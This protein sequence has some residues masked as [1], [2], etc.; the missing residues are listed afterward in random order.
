MIRNRC[1]KKVAGAGGGG[2]FLDPRRGGPLIGVGVPRG[3]LRSVLQEHSTKQ[4]TPTDIRHSGIC[5]GSEE[6][7]GSDPKR[8]LLQIRSGIRF[9]S[10]AESASDLMQN[11]FRI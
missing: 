7:P 11:P 4:K 10:E 8:I 2:F 3:A 9:G 1:G 5:F 6:E